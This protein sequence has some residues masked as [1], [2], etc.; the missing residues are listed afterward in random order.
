[1]STA[2]VPVAISVGS[3]MSQVNPLCLRFQTDCCMPRTVRE[4]PQGDMEGQSQREAPMLVEGCDTGPFIY[5]YRLCL[6]ATFRG[7]NS[8]TDASLIK[9]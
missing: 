6:G 7:G 4:G 9:L 2:R 1:V 8:A 5:R 3:T